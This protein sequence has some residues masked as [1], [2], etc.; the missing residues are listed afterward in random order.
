MATRFLGKP[1][2]VAGDRADRWSPEPLEHGCHRRTA[3]EGPNSQ[4]N[5]P[6]E[7]AD[8]KRFFKSRNTGILT[9]VAFLF[10]C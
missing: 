6:K 5:R 2:A 3:A 7:E 1:L 8:E 9:V 4:A 10:G